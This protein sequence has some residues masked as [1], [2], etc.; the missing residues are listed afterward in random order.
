MPRSLTVRQAKLVLPQR[1]VT[2]DIVVQDGVIAEVAPHASREVG[3]VIDGSGLCVLPGLIDTQVRLDGLD[4]LDQ[5]G[6]EVVAGGITSFVGV[7]AATDADGL[8]REL[9]ALG[10]D[11]PVNHGLYVRLDTD[12][13]NAVDTALAAERAFGVWVDADQLEHAEPVFERATGLVVVDHRDVARLRDRW[14]LFDAPPTPSDL[15]RFYDIDTCV[16]GAHR[17]LELAA[18]HGTRTHLLHI[19]TA[20]ELQLL[21]DNQRVT[22]TVRPH[23]LFADASFY[24]AFGTRAVCVPP[25]RGP[26]HAEAL[27]QALGEGRL[28]LTSG[29]FPASAASKDLPLPATH[30]G[31]PT[32][33]WMLPLLLDAHSRGRCTLGDI[34]RWTSAAPAEH[35]GLRRK[36]RLVPGYDADLV[37]VDLARSGTVG[38]DRPIGSRAGWSPWVGRTLKGWPVQVIVGGETAWLD[39]T[40]GP[41]QGRPLRPDPA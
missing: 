3:E 33:E 9:S 28:W 10:R 24:E 7:R 13:T 38:A 25:L 36:G 16:D 1:T 18:R 15:P 23:H 4:E 39:G 22:A 6:A 31:W 41:A 29:H 35:L 8:R 27:W 26:R 12:I 40:V 37:L 34:A 20:E 32:A 19:S 30:P 14:H 11:C 21:P 5:A 17:V 2:G